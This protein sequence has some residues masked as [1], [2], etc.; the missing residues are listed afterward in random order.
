MLP[1]TASYLDDRDRD[2]EPQA[3]GRIFLDLHKAET[4]HVQKGLPIRRTSPHE[5]MSSRYE[6]L[7]LLRTQVFVGGFQLGG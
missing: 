3:Y 5:V 1:F 4:R 7:G 6:L 2:R